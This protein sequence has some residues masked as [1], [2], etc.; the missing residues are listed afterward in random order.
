MHRK[1]QEPGSLT[2]LLRR[3]PQL[4]GTR[5]L[6]FH[7][8]SRSGL[9]VGSGCGLLAANG[10]YSFL[11]ELPWGSPGDAG[12]PQSLMTGIL[13][14]WRGSKHS[15]S[16]LK[17]QRN[18]HWRLKSYKYSPIFFFSIF[19]ILFFVINLLWNLFQSNVRNQFLKNFIYSWLKDNCFTKLFVKKPNF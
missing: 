16:W 1:I 19:V 15:V 12:G 9:T 7:I 2:P 6:C 13:V 4:S 17:H 8:L 18:S 14:Y 3:V 11:P 10:R 5:I